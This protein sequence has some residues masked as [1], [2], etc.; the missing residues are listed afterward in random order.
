V[1]FYNRQRELQTIQEACESCSAEQVI[2]YGRRGVGKS[3]LLATA[4]NGRRHIY[5][6]AMRRTLPLQL[7]ALTDA[8]HL[9]YPD[10]FLPGPFAR[11]DDFLELLSRLA[12]TRP[13]EPVIAVIDELPYLEEAEPGV[14]TALQHWWD[15][16]KHLPNLKM[17]L[18]GSYVSFMERQVLG[19]HAP[20]YNRRTGSLKLEPVRYFEAA[21]FF[22]SYTTREQIEAFAILGGMPSYLEQFDPASGIDANLLRT[23]LRSSTYLNEEPE[24]LLRQDLRNEATY[25]SI[26]QAMAA[27]HRR[28]SDIAR[29]IGRQS[30]QD[31]A[32]RLQDLRDL[33]IIRREVPITDRHRPHARTSLY[34]LA[35][36]YLSFWYRFVGPNQALISEGRGDRVLARIRD[37]FG[38]YVSRPP[39]EEVCRQFLLHAY[40]HDRLPTGLE[41]EAIGSWWSGTTEIDI[42][43]QRGSSTTLAGSCKWTNAPVGVDELQRL[44]AAVEAQAGVLHPA[45]ACYYALFSRSGFDAALRSLAAEAGSRVLL[46]T[47]DHLFQPNSPMAST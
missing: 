35:D 45:P 32:P 13:D 43:A 26:L 38:E 17:F 46:F 20:L 29:A 27:G 3:A 22:P 12:E 18:T 16:S 33:D 28:P 5:F 21:L 15:R 4:L 9:A 42:V 14:L 1:R 41:I 8:A 2:V 44:R 37:R 40:A 10:T 23:A 39:F 34:W 11:V 6:R 30:A 7:A 24:W 36:N 25:G 47:P 31:V 19:V